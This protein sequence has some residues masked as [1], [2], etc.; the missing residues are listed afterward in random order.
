MMEEWSDGFNTP[1][2][3]YSSTPMHFNMRLISS[4]TPFVPAKKKPY[5]MFCLLKPTIRNSK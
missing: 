3:Q 4:N 5:F 1:M 2:L